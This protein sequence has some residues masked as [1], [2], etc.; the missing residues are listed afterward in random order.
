VAYWYQDE[1]HAAQPPLPPAS[2]RIPMYMRLQ[3]RGPGLFEAEDFVDESTATRGQ[4]QDSEVTFFGE[5]FSRNAILEW[6]A[7]TT[8]SKMTLHVP[9]TSEGDHIVSMTLV[10]TRRGGGFRVSS[11]SVSEEVDL[12]TDSIFPTTTTL[13]LKGAAIKSGRNDV[14]FESTTRHPKAEAWTV[15]LDQIS[16][17]ASRKE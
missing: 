11:G 17:S 14:T 10:K 2:D 9:A 15:A 5:M 12:Y 6:D 4:I 8:G 1:P 16:L 3:E 13:V 7:Q